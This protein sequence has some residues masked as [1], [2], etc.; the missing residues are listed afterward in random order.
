MCGVL[1][2]PA[3]RR[4][5][6]A[7]GLASLGDWLGLLALTAL[8]QSL[9]GDSY[10][11]A[12]LAVAG[13]FLLR[14]APAVVLGPVAGVVAD[15]LDRRATMVV[16]NLL[17]CA[18]LVSIPL[19]GRL[20]WLF[21][22]TFLLEAASLFFLPAKDASIPNLVPREQL[23]AANSLNL[24]TTYGSAPVAAALFAGLSLFSGVL[25]NALGRF[26]NSLAATPAAVAIWVNAA[27]FL[28]SAVLIAR[29]AG[30]GRSR[31]A[32]TAAAPLW[33][34]VLDGWTFIGRTPV[35]RGL[36]VG[37]L[38]AF[39]AGGVVVGL[40]RTYVHDLGAGDPGYGVLFGVVFLGMAAGMGLGPRLF[41]GFSRRRLFGLAISLA[42]VSLALLALI[43]NIVIAVLLTF[44]I[45]GWAGVA[46]VT[47]YTMLGSEVADDVRGRTFAFV[48]TM[49][50][51][52]LVGVLALAPLLAAALGRHTLRVSDV[53]VAYN[54]AAMAFLLAGAVAVIVGATAYRQMDDRPGVPL[55]ADLAAAVRGTP[56]GPASATGTGFFLA[57]EGGEGAG[58][59][60]Q[61]E[62]LAAALRR[63]GYE[64]VVTREPGGTLL[65]ERLRDLLLDPASGGLTARGEALLYAADRAQHVATV[66]RPA[67]VRGAIVVSD[68]YLDSSIAYQGG[69]RTLAPDDVSRISLW[70]TQGLL[71]Q[72]TVVLDVPPEIG[73]T[74]FAV[75]AD[76]LEGE[77]LTFH[78]RVRQEFRRLAGRAP[79]RYLVV[80]ATL[81][82]EEITAQILARLD[83]MLP[84]S[85]LVEAAL[86]EQRR[87][88][89]EERA[90]SE[91]AVA[92]RRRQD[93]AERQRAAAAAAEQ[94]RREAE[95][96]A[97]ERAQ[98]ET[99]AAARRAARAAS[100]EAQREAARRVEEKRARAKTR[101]SSTLPRSRSSGDPRPPDPRPRADPR[102]PGVAARA[103][104]DGLLGR[105][106]RARS[107]S[108][109][110]AARPR[111]GGPPAGDPPTRELPLDERLSGVPADSG[112]AGWDAPTREIGPR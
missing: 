82:A 48:Q 91:A 29:V 7:L 110:A 86:A 51:V 75:P 44:A 96:R 92:E 73:L 28:V 12:N 93:E 26:A 68:R 108:R 77:P 5:W 101:R 24:L 9:S 74:R 2:V 6:V 32:H 11:I 104:S 39:A 15:R 107:G 99:E 20:W 63:R 69:G 16:T 58:K 30:I 53:V 105:L 79:Q 25:D 45:G 31:G 111:G 21:V 100:R 78:E 95:A 97:R 80:D 42:G 38:G 70:A 54:G 43:P 89:D 112:E 37:M 84:S 60:T 56:I 47:G 88:Q 46:W 33:R 57:L 40:A 72:L 71:P 17:R 4:L 98:R 22:A 65:G 87:Q 62:R 19:V 55:V 106:R 67:L 102:S 85:T 36:V 90:R 83:G 35:V 18:L 23:E 59:S 49:V 109:T 66:I 10:A 81:P 50:R 61:A 94:R 27:T 8:A 103:G 14:L 76:R 1:G 13:V 64:V 3:F 52:T 34:T 41:G